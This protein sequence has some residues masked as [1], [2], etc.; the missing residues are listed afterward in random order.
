MPDGGDFKKLTELLVDHRCSYHRCSYCIV[1]C[2]L[3]GRWQPNTGKIWSWSS[4]SGADWSRGILRKGTLSKMPA[5]LICLCSRMA[6]FGS[7]PSNR[8]T[9][10]LPYHTRCSE[11][12]DGISTVLCDGIW[13]RLLGEN[14]SLGDHRFVW[15]DVG[16]D[17]AR[18]L[19]RLNV[20]VWAITFRGVLP[21][22]ETLQKYAPMV[23]GPLWTTILNNS[24]GHES[25]IIMI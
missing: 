14:G 20:G 15:L 2:G 10:T 11:T 9:S 21:R 13:S 3:F 23:L 18:W 6:R 12:F 8:T 19:L 7:G 4:C 25:G 22:I 16:L 5:Y 24:C 1:L 17:L